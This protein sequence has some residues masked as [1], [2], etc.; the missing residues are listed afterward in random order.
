MALVTNLDSAEMASL[1]KSLLLVVLSFQYGFR[2]MP[3]GFEDDAA[4]PWDRAVCRI[5]ILIFSRL[6][7]SIDSVM[8]FSSAMASCVTG[9]GGTQGNGSG[10][11]GLDK[12]RRCAEVRATSRWIGRLVTLDG[13]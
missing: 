12:A 2:K 3:A 10:V 9:P 4:N 1:G 8:V 5:F 11:K 7:R 6:S 13:I